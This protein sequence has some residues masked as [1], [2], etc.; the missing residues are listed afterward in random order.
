MQET[1]LTLFT[2]VTALVP[3]SSLKILH[4]LLSLAFAVNISSRIFSWI[5]SDCKEVLIS[6]LS[7]I[8]SHALPSLY[9]CLEKSS[10]RQCVAQESTASKSEMTAAGYK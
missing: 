5:V 3:L 6:A 10:H 2:V 1:K 9:L 4:D 8:I 7:T